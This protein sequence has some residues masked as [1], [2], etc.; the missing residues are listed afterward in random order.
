M[1]R[2]QTLAVHSRDPHTALKH[3]IVSRTNRDGFEVVLAR[4]QW[5]KDDVAYSLHANPT[6]YGSSGLQ[7]TD[8]L[9]YLGFQRH[10]RCPFTGFGRC[11]ARWVDPGFD[12]ESFADAFLKGY[13]ELQRAEAGLSACGFVLPQPEGWN[14]FY[15]KP[16]GASRDNRQLTLSG[17]GHTAIDTKRMKAI[18]D[19]NFLYRF[20]FV[21]TGRERGF[22]THYRP[23][24]PPLSS[25]LTSVFRYLRLREFQE[26]PEFEFEGCYYRTLLFEQRGSGAFENNTEH[27]HRCFDA[28]ARQFSPAIESLLTAN[29]T[30]EVA[31]MTFLSIPQARERDQADI[32]RKIVLPK[33]PPSARPVTMALDTALP[34]NF[35]VA[36]SFA[37]TE[38]AA[39]EELARILQAAGIAVFYDNFYPEHLW[40][41]NLTAFL[42]EIYRKR[43]KYCVVFVSKEYRERRW[44]SHEL[45]SAQARA[46]ESKGEDYILPVKIDDT[47][48]DGLPPTIGYMSIDVGIGK[49]AELLIAKLKG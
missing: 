44:T 32:V 20:T 36:I 14:Y 2:I 38:R 25:E 16:G 11:Y 41:K 5:G 27:A 6:S 37:G 22:V 34:S 10:D 13:A 24:H 46:L 33:S 23:K 29:S 8:F 35:D 49:I 40:G 47:D 30:L 19:L 45:R 43:A 21:T 3:E 18:E 17:D 48:L 12:I 28:H 7:K 4:L 9:S 39:A 26:C 1:W 42:D 31:G 15:A